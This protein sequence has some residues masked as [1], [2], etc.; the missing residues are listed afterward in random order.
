VI[1]AFTTCTLFGLRL[2][3]DLPTYA[4]TFARNLSFLIINLLAAV[5]TFV[6]YCVVLIYFVTRYITF[7]SCVMCSIEYLEVQDIEEQY[8]RNLIKSRRDDMFKVSYYL[9]NKKKQQLYLLF[10]N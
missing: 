2:A 8:V 4:I 9:C 1:G 10:F 7:E 6:A 5:P 3:L